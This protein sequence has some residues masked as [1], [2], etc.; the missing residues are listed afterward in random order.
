MDVP[1]LRVSKQFKAEFDSGYFFFFIAV[2]Y[3]VSLLELVIVREIE[4]LTTMV[5]IALL[6]DIFAIA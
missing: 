6:F 3:S 1:A 2:T 4:R 5:L